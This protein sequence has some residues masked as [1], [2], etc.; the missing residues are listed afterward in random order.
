M[1]D[2]RKAIL[3]H[4][5]V[6]VACLKCHGLGVIAYASTSTWCGG[7]GGASITKDVCDACWGSGDAEQPWTDLRRLRS[8]ESA[9]VAAAAASLFADRC[10]VAFRSVRPG[11][12]EL[13]GE[14]ARL[15]RGR[16]ARAEGFGVACLCLAKLLVELV[17]VTK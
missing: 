6:D 11:L 15:G 16:K 17:E 1:T 4:R 12:Q 9:R 13:A 5:G 8:E 7:M 10:G 3:H 2:L 14:I